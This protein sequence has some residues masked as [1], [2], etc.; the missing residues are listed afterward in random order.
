MDDEQLFPSKQRE[1]RELANPLSRGDREESPQQPQL[2][3][4]QARKP[5]SMPSKEG[6]DSDAVFGGAVVLS[7]E[8]KKRARVLLNDS[9]AQ[10][11]QSDLAQR[12]RSPTPK[13]PSSLPSLSQPDAKDF[14]TFPSHILAHGHGDSTNDSF[15]KEKGTD[16]KEEAVN[17]ILNPAQAN[18]IDEPIRNT[19]GQ[20]ESGTESGQSSSNEEEKDEEESIPPS[21][22]LRMEAA[23]QGLGCKQIAKWEEMFERLVTFKKENGHCLVP[24]RYPP[25]PSLGSWVSTQRRQYK[26]MNLK[27]WYETTPMSPERVTRLES[28]GFAWETKDPRH[29]LWETRFEQLV[30][31]KEKHGRSTQDVASCPLQLLTTIVL[32]FSVVRLLTTKGHCLV[33]IGYKVRRKA[34][35]MRGQYTHICF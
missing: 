5:I 27:G 31:Y 28:I 32:V 10:Q 14:A 30:K 21:K 26:I 12:E 16:H 8:T 29:V 9:S 17:G 24:N 7:E 20:S 3:F 34:R 4:D 1:G 13:S 22:R 2:R 18:S 19:S 11:H 25:D 15:P 6:A 35:E 33:P 23:R